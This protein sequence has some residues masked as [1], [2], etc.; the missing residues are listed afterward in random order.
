M[1]KAGEIRQRVAFE[2]ERRSRLGVPVAASGVIYLLGA[3]I[4]YNQL[5]N[6]PTV[7]LIQGLE[8]AL[9]GKPEAVVSPRAAELKYISHHALGFIAGGLFEALGIAAATLALLFLLDVT[10]FREAT[11]PS[12][13]PR[14]LV[15]VGGAGAALVTVLAQVVRVIRSHNFAVG[16]NFSDH[17]VESAAYTG[18]VNVTLEFFTLVLPIVLAVGMV[19]ALLRTTRVGLI[20]RWLRT[21]GIVAAVL[22]LPFFSATLFTLQLIPAAWLVFTGI[23]FMGRLPSGDPPA[24]ASGEAKPWPPPE[25][26]LARGSGATEGDEGEA[27][28]HSEQA[29]IAAGADRDHDA[30]AND[31]APEDEAPDEE[32]PDEDGSTPAPMA[33]APGSSSKRRRRKRG[34]QR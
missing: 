7:G 31:A 29:A 30:E 9:R 16:H 2:S 1:S 34:G 5:S 6:L 24:W 21:L 3:I 8:P 10:R 20:P 28:V 18:A 27:P 15:L 4:L 11:E 13:T 33:S 23:L 14:M 17:A 26:R 22:L 12:P 25:G 19:I 32:A